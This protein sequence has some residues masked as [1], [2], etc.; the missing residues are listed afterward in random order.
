MIAQG[1]G[2]VAAL[3]VGSTKVVQVVAGGGEIW[4]LNEEPE[5]S[6]LA[7]AWNDAL[8]RLTI[9]E[10]GEPTGNDFSWNPRNCTLDVF[11]MEEQT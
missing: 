5:T 11:E 2:N 8:M 9:S 3:R 7:Y 1:I 10:T 6:A 4:P